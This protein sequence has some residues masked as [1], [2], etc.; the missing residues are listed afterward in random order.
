MKCSVLGNIPGKDSC[1]HSRDQT[2]GWILPTI[3]VSSS[4]SLKRGSACCC[5]AISY[6]RYYHIPLSPLIH[7]SLSLPFVLAPRPFPARAR[8]HFHL[9]AGPHRETLSPF[10]GAWKMRVLLAGA[11]LAIRIYVPCPVTDTFYAFSTLRSSRQR[12]IFSADASPFGVKREVSDRVR[13]QDHAWVI[14]AWES[15]KC[16]DPIA[17]ALEK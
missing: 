17:R 6:L 5:A 12:W 16:V 8:A 9:P 3:A 2:S 14:A 4:S 15:T 11:L 13:P 1:T 10:T 7:A